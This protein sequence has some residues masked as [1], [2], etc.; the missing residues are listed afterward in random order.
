MIAGLITSKDVLLH[1]S[2][3][4]REYGIR[5]YL[6]GLRAVV[7]RRRTTFLGLLWPDPGRDSIVAN[8]RQVR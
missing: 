6:Q 1:T 2:S 8:R 4:V 3:I 7:S 5:C